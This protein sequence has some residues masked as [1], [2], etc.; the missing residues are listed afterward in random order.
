M[1]AMGPAG[2]GPQ[3]GFP[4]WAEVALRPPLAG[5][6]KSR[7][8]D[9]AFE[10]DAFGRIIEVNSGFMHSSDLDPSKLINWKRLLAFNGEYGSMGDLG[11]HACHMPFRV[12]D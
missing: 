2:R 11:M 8:E 3:A 10:G 6:C 5:P 12:I 1:S 4:P 9:A 7:A